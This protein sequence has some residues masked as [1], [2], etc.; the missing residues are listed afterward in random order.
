MSR[1]D[2]FSAHGGTGSTPQGSAALLRD[3]EGRHGASGA[4]PTDAELA[5]TGEILAVVARGHALDPTD[6]LHALLTAWRAELL[7]GPVYAGPTLDDA[8]DALRAG[9]RAAGME[10]TW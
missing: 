10:P 5:R 3:R 2:A 9:I 1:S 7:A 8:M 6:V 4:L